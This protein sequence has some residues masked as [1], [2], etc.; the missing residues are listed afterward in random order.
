[1]CTDSK[2]QIALCTFADTL[3]SQVMIIMK[4][5]VGKGTSCPVFMQINAFM[6]CSDVEMLDPVI[7]FLFYGCWAGA[8][9]DMKPVRC[10]QSS[11]LSCDDVHEAKFLC[12]VYV[13]LL[14]YC[15]V[16]F[17]LSVDGYCYH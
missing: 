10:C 3:M 1:M 7:Y 15:T 13:R 11:R 17:K 4:Q 12:Q 16:G 5:Q 9:G 14:V 8:V 2:V 6:N